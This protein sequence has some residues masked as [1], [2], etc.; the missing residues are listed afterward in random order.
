MPPKKGGR[1]R[2][3]EETPDAEEPSPSSG[4]RPPTRQGVRKRL[5][6][7]DAGTARS[8]PTGGA[9]PAVR[10]GVRQRLA[11]A[12]RESMGADDAPPTDLPFNRSLK[13][14]WCTGK[15]SSPDVQEIAEGMTAQHGVGAEQ[16]AQAG[17]SGKNPQNIM[18]SL[19][20]RF[21]KPKG[22]PEQTFVRIPSAKGTIFHPVFLPHL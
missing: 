13:I 14:K 3:L 11:D 20:A 5:D 17:S 15:L 8:A 18:S 7:D 9:D 21:G 1:K 4:V 22:V 10:G 16:L 19:I 2:V 6:L 12:K